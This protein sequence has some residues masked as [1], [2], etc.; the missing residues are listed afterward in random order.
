MELDKVWVIMSGS[1][2]V[3]RDNNVVLGTGC[4]ILTEH[5]GRANIYSTYEGALGHL[6]V[7]QKKS[8]WDWARHVNP[9]RCEIYRL[10]PIREPALGEVTEF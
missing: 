8:N 4:P 2:Y 6:E 3:G 9:A 5:L 1:Q 7:I 10:A